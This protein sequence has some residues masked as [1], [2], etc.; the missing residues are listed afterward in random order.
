[1]TNKHITFRIKGLEKDNENVQ[2]DDFIKQL[3][4]VKQSLS[5]VDKTVSQSNQETL[6]YRV[7]NLSHNNPAIIELEAVPLDEE[8]NTSEVVINRFYSG[9]SQIYTQGT[10][11]EDFDYDVLQAFSSLTGL[12]NKGI[13][14]LTISTNGSS[15]PITTP[16]SDKVNEIL[17]EDVF[18]FG[19]I[20]GMLD[21]LNLHVNPPVFTV[22]STV[23]GSKLQCNF[24]RNLRIIVLQAVGQYVTVY[25]RI[26]YKSRGNRPIEMDVDEIEIHPNEEDLP[27]MSELRGI[28]PDALDGKTIEEF[29]WEI[30]F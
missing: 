2:F 6:Y 29:L 19:S 15:L 5:E 7:V 20:T 8:K 16:L 17:G 22:Y 11:P 13:T 14:E 27:T 10:A 26:K 9:I 3:T 12:L 25:G 23:G 18:E 30:K 24:R 21:Q 28:A 1:M 4:F